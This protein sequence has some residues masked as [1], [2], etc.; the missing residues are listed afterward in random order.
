MGITR[1]EMN[2]L[3]PTVDNP[4]GKAI[5]PTDGAQYYEYPIYPIL[6]HFRKQSSYLLYFNI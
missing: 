5:P 6:G 1:L 4:I 3:K 2:V